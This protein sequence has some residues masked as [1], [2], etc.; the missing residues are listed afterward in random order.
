MDP[1]TDDE[2][3]VERNPSP[4]PLRAREDLGGGEP[5]AHRVQ[6]ERQVNQDER[7]HDHGGQALEGEQARL[8]DYFPPFR[9]IIRALFFSPA[10]LPVGL[11]LTGQCVMQL[12]C[13]WQALQP[14]PEV[15]LRSTSFGSA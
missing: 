1:D 5:A 10:M 12:P 11:R 7:R 13:V 8:H 4:T 14:L 2:Q 6:D 15:A 3:G 9:N